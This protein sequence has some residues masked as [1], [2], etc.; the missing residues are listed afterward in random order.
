M[1][2]QVTQ[3]VLTLSVVFCVIADNYFALSEPNSPHL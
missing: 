2:G 3:L 1:G